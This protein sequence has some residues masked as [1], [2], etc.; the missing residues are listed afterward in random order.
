MPEA[1]QTELIGSH[2]NDPL[3]GHFGIKKIYE[4]LAEKYFWPSMRHDV[5]A[6]V[7]SCDVCLVSKAVRHKPYS[8]LQSL[9]VPTHRWKDLSIDF[10]TSLSISTEW[11]EDIYDFILVIID[12]LTKMVHY[13]LVKI[14]I[15]APDLAEVIINIVVR[16]HGLPDLIVTD[17]GSLLTW[18]FWLLLCHFLGIK[19]WLSTAFHPQTDVQIEWQNRTIKAYLQAFINFKQND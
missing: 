2:H 18:K 4:R 13:E 6:Y 15:N 16:H 3:A 17:R 11:K 19:R 1:I 12:R 10:V 8:D 14:T 5:E 9:S 7:K